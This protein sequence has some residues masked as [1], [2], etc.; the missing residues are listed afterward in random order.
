MF[1]F[2]CGGAWLNFIRPASHRCVIST[3]SQGSA[4]GIPPRLMCHVGSETTIRMMV[5]LHLHLHNP[6]SRWTAPQH[7]RLTPPS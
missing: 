1:I 5:A 7:T 4:L 6:K 3:Q 2:V